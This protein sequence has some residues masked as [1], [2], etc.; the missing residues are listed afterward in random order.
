MTAMRPTDPVGW[1]GAV[2]M[3]IIIVT[4]PTTSCGRPVSSVEMLKVYTGVSIAKI[5]DMHALASAARTETGEGDLNN[6]VADLNL[7]AQ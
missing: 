1:K 6:D 7:R 4:H 3:L 5:Q 2:T